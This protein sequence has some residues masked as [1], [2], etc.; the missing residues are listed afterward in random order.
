MRPVFDCLRVQTKQLF[1]PQ[2]RCRTFCLGRVPEYTPIGKKPCALLRSKLAYS[3]CPRKQQ[4]PHRC[5]CVAFRERKRKPQ[6]TLKFFSIALL[7]AYDRAKK[8]AVAGGPGR[9]RLPVNF[10]P[11]RQILYLGSGAKRVKSRATCWVRNSEAAMR[12]NTESGSR[13]TTPSKIVRQRA[14]SP[15]LRCKR[16]SR[17]RKPA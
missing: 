16:A 2:R 7:E 5:A 8:L 12:P 17:M 4:Q 13:A 15:S 14:K 9:Q 10:C 11:S 6:R 3:A 1:C